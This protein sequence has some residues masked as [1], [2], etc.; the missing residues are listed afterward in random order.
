[1]QNK[2]YE[3]YVGIDVSKAILDVAL[4]DGKKP[5]QFKN[6]E[7]GLAGL[8]KV[9]PASEPTLIIFEASG[10]YEVFPCKF[11]QAKG[12]NV[13]VVNAKRVRDYASAHGVLAKTDKI[14]A[15]MIRRYGQGINPRLKEQLNPSQEAL[16][17]TATRRSQL[18]KLITA[19]KNHLILASKEIRK[20]IK[21][22]IKYLEKQLAAMDAT[23]DDL[24]STDTEIK[25]KL[26]KLAGIKGVGKITA[27]NVVIGLPE[28]GHLS[29]KE[30][31]A[32]AG[33]APFNKDSGK[34]QGKR[35][36]WGGRGE[37]RA[38]LYMAILSAKRFNPPLKAF[39]DRLISKG[40]LKKVAMVA[41]MRKLIIIMNAM[42]RDNAEWQ[43][44]LKLA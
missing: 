24:A 9:L 4:D 39:Y 38:A 32:L 42:I 43:P 7:E 1:M 3:F 18:I 36:I 41:C 34:K 8:L 2:S 40:K 20:G 28:L 23:L 12:F 19:E 5:L 15:R 6:D 21:A 10:G 44:N 16:A 37:L 11:L 33:V 22:T 25:K 27:M 35:E 31:A 29:P 26:D 17:A 30:V 14:D 13:A